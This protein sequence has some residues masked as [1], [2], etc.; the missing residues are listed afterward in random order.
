MWTRLVSDDTRSWCVG[1]VFISTHFPPCRQVARPLGALE[2]FLD[3]VFCFV[4]PWHQYTIESD[5]THFFVVDG[6]C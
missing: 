5:N 3:S 6:S 1:R 2:F 4:S